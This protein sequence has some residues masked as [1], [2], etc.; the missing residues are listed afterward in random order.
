MTLEGATRPNV[1]GQTHGQ[2]D[3]QTHA[4]KPESTYDIFCRE[5]KCAF[6]AII[7]IVEIGRFAPPALQGDI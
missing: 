7:Q 4:D 6:G 5:R 2:T 1:L 3:T